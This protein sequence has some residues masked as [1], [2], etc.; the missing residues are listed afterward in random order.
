MLRAAGAGSRDPVQ[1]GLPL[2]AAAGSSSGR[3]PGIPR[4]RNRAGSRGVRALRTR[5]KEPEPEP[6][7]ELQVAL[8]SQ[9]PVLFARSLHENIAYGLGGRSR[10]EVT[11]AARR[12]NAHG[13]ITRLSHGYD[14]DVGEM[15]GQ[16]SGGQRQGVAI[17]RAL[18]R[19]PRVLILDDATSA[20]DTEGQLLVEKEIYEGAW[21]GRSVL[22]IA[23]RLSAVERADR[24]LVLEDGAIREQGTHRELLARRGSYWRLAQT[25]L[26]GEQGGGSGGGLGAGGP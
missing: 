12:A 17:A 25:Q 13:F 26:N 19:D 16:I 9:K 15:G 22:L 10:Q 1:P 4:K 6:E 2:A 18:L 11:G 24:I 20:L 14:T 5:E 3:G 7:P 21:A 23:H 8:V